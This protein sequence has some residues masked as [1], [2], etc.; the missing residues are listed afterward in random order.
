[1]SEKITALY[2]SWESPISADLI[3]SQGSIRFFSPRAD[4]DTLYWIELRP[5]EGGRCVLVCQKNGGKPQDILMEQYSVR[6]RVHEYGGG[7]YTVKDGV[8]YFCNDADQRIYV[9]DLQGNISALSPDGSYRYADMLV[10]E[11]H[12]QLICILE[13]HSI[14][15]QE[16]ENSLVAIDLKT[17]KLK[18]CLASG[19]NF[20]ASPRLSPDGTQ[21]AWLTWSHPNMPWDGTEL[22]LADLDKEGNIQLPRLIAGG[23]SESVFQPE[24]APDG[25]LFFVSDRTNW[26]NLYCFDQ[27]KVDAIIP[28]QAEFGLPQWVFGQ[29]TFDFLSTDKLVVTYTD[30]GF[31]YL[32][33]ID[34]TSGTLTTY[35]L[36]YTDYK[37]PI[38][39]GGCVFCFASSPTELD[40]VLLI[41]PIKNKAHV[42]KTKG[43][44]D[45]DSGYFSMPQ[46]V[47][48]PTGNGEMAY[49][50]F[51]P[52][53]NPKFEAPEG[54]LPPLLVKSHSGPTAMTS[55]NL[56]LTF[57]YWTTR[58]FAVLD[59]NY[60][61]STGYG[62]PYRERLNGNWGIVDVQDCAAGAIYLAKQGLVDP[63]KLT[64]DGG[65]A[66]GYTTLSALTF[67][68]V[69]AAGSSRYGIGDLNALAKETH[70]FEARYLDN[71]VGPYPQ[72][73][74]VYDERSPLLHADHLNTPVIFFQGAEDKVV[75]P[76]QTVNMV[77]ALKAKGLPVAFLLFE[78]EQHG[79]R[80]AESIKR[81]LEGQLFFYAKILGNKLA[82]EIEPVEIENF[83]E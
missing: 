75:P 46:P 6:T 81:A 47:S 83:P 40:A 58:G 72:K 44:I 2:G 24:F 43:M 36:P 8:V 27:G 60:G 69:F 49:G 53:T 74:S 13:D 35:D 9:R 66:G 11:I 29:R 22:F 54:T 4:G 19:N 70:K 63:K 39:V 26:W 16:E 64:I 3:L 32:G 37:S 55:V 17:G 73:K 14:P 51:Y 80:K 30:Q 21:L 5:T 7:E 68:N 18:H 48:F 62:R 42:I 67:T 45:L 56:S 59:V 77:N 12:S 61:G 78:G 1:M 57:Q 52:P 28:M 31:W 34:L 65:S 50:I 15:G 25:S 79:F 10:D 82:D 41:D 38:A 23:K 76:N 20:Y 71:L 33:E